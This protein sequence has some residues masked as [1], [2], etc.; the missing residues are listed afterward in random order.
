[1]YCTEVYWKLERTLHSLVPRGLTLREHPTD[2]HQ[3]QQRRLGQIALRITATATSTAITI[4]IS[5]QALADMFHLFIWVSHRILRSWEYY[6]LQTPKLI[7]LPKLR[8]E[9]FKSLYEKAG[10]GNIQ[11]DRAETKRADCSTRPSNSNPSLE[12]FRSGSSPLY[13]Y[14]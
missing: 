14:Y 9:H 12:L 1:M 13:H 4:S 2:Q 6:Q 3:R 7:K 10:F 5:V 8:M 11:P